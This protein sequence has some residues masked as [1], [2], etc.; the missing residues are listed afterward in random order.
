M[1]YSQPVS[2]KSL[3]NY[4]QYCGLIVGSSNLAKTL[5]LW[6]LQWFFLLIFSTFSFVH[7]YTTNIT[8]DLLPTI[9]NYIFKACFCIIV[10][11]AT[12]VKVPFSRFWLNLIY[13]LAYI[14]VFKTT[15]FSSSFIRTFNYFPLLSHHCLA[16]I[17]C[18]RDCRIIVGKG[19]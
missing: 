12:V 16:Y 8:L 19:L 2:V 18:L 1:F 4:N 10:T 11:C 17:L 13:N 7:I 6:K 3:Y 15:R 9:E 5:L 14:Y